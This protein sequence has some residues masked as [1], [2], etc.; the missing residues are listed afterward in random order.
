MRQEKFDNVIIGS[1][2]LVLFVLS[3]GF[4]VLLSFPQAALAAVIFTPTAN[5]AG[6]NQSSNVFDFGTQSIGTPASDR[7]V[8]VGVAS[9]KTGTL[10][11]VT[12]GG[13][14]AT[15]AANPGNPATNFW[16]SIWYASIASGS[17][18]D[19][20][21][22]YSSGSIGNV[23]A[24]VGTLNG[25]SPTPYDSESTT[26]DGCG[27]PTSVTATVPANGAGVAIGLYGGPSQSI[28]WTGSTN[29]PN[30]DY[31]TTDSGG[32]GL[33]AGLAHTLTSGSDTMSFPTPGCPNGNAVSFATW[34]PAAPA[35][36]GRIIRLVG[37][38]RLIGGVRLE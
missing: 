19:I 5:P 34:G 31:Y 20:T 24:M 4:P 28:A 9:N 14:P 1:R 8:V 38:L 3:V 26:I 11:S 2:S 32:N 18:A 27:D 21:A 33:S 25:A 17:T 22:T 6:F 7:I 10:S 35:S 29:D 37:G 15:E 13:T 16:T 30:G 12:I 23:I 36:T